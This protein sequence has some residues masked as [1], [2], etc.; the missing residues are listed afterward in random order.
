MKKNI[1]TSFLKQENVFFVIY[2]WYDN[3]IAYCDNFYN[4]I[5]FLR[6]LGWRSKP[7][8]LAYLFNR[9]KYDYI[10]IQK[11]DDLLKLYYYTDDD[12]LNVFI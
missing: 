6:S 7:S 11:S 12:L 4:L 5:Y 1:N 9:S 10:Q 8:N 2:D 3:L